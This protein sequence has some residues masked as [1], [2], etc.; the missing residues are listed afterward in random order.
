MPINNKMTATVN[1][2]IFTSSDRTN[3]V[4]PLLEFIPG[5]IPSRNKIE[6]QATVIEVNKPKPIEIEITSLVRKVLLLKINNKTTTEIM[7]T[8]N[9][10]QNRFF[11]IVSILILI[12]C[13]MYFRSPE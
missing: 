5:A 2:K 7:G 12:T 9:A 11:P 1:Q 6:L 8:I 3:A 10:S 13:R 4:I